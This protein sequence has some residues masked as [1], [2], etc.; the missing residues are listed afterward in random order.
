MRPK[1]LLLGCTGEVGSRLTLA[2]IAS[3]YEVIGIHGVSQCTLES[4]FHTCKEFDLLNPMASVPFNEIKADVLIHT[5]WITTPNIFWNSPKNYEWLEASKRIISS[6][7]VSGGKFLV[8][9]GS[10]AEYSWETD[11]PI[12]EGQLELP[13]TIYGKSKLDLLNWLRNR[14]IPYL[15]TRTFFQF[16][17]NEP[18]GRLI[19]SL[20][21]SLL[22][23]E[24]FHVK[25]GDDIRDFVY[26]EDIVRILQ[27]LILEEK[28]GVVNIGSG[29]GTRVEDLA[30]NIGKLL[31][32]E[33][34]I[35]YGKSSDSKSSII[36]NPSR[37]I[38]LY[39]EYDWTPL[40]TALTQSIEA[41]TLISTR[42]EW[43]PF[44]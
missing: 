26:I 21:D 44:Q 34:L 24:K 19:P 17:S 30:S 9:T 31:G 8:V 29:T 39:G 18:T 40:T 35:S 4:P 36:S 12:S 33:H 28:V 41:R 27:G 13:E 1:V 6:F 16:G 20:I 43:R 14:S 23:G 22:L 2:L 10:C 11:E 25:S 32:K 7:E 5:S 38:C 42:S 3:G 37:L 15:W